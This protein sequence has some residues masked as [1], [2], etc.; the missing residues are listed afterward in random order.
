[1]KSGLRQFSVAN[2]F[3]KFS[4]LY[5]TYIL[6]IAHTNWYFGICSVKFL[7]MKFSHFVKPKMWTSVSVNVIFLYSLPWL[8]TS[9]T[10]LDGTVN[11]KSNPKSSQ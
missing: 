5:Y 6:H 4:Y 2:S 8:L 9:D 7:V 1:M 10:I 11:L 3:M